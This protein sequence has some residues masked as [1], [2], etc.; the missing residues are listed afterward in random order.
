[1]R[2]F[3]KRLLTFC[4]ILL[5]FLMFGLLGRDVDIMQ[6]KAEMKLRSVLDSKSGQS[7]RRVVF[8]NRIGKSGSR[9][10]IYMVNRLAQ[11]LNYTSSHS[12]DYSND[13]P[14]NEEMQE[15]MKKI[16]ELKAP[17]FYNRHIHFLDFKKFGY[18]E[19]IYIN[20][21]R[22]PIERFQSQYNYI[23]YGDGE[24]E[25]KDPRPEW[26]DINECVTK[27]VGVC[28]TNFMFYIGMYFCGF[29]PVC[30]SPS[31]ARV[32][33]A[34][35]HIDENFVFIGV[36]EEMDKSLMLLQKMLPEYFLGAF[37]DYEKWNS[38]RKTRTNT[39]DFLTDESIHELRSRLMEDEYEVYLYAKRKYQSLK[40]KYEIHD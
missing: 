13:H 36:T 28:A 11:T 31:E 10:I 7:R 15:E 18:K 16:S 24:S 30:E 34:K 23:K 29:D 22:D 12:S 27:R 9:T 5:I 37:D 4:I 2:P 25:V 3:R 39:K 17:A 6:E 8:Y 26:P 19:P 38:K 20:M 33:L 1:M 40:E 32:R 35:K 14:S 21:V